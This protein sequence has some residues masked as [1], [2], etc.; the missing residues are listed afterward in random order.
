MSKKV[1]KGE[2]TITDV[3]DSIPNEV[4]F[5]YCAV[6]ST[7]TKSFVIT[8]VTPG[9][10]KFSVRSADNSP[11]KISH[12]SGVLQVK[13]KQEITF[14]YSPAECE[15]LVSSIVVN[16]NG[17]EDKQI[18]LLAVAK[19]QLLSVSETTLDFQELLVGKSEIKE[20]QIHNTGHVP[21]SFRVRKERN[22][23][24]DTSFFVAN[25]KGNIAVGES[26]TV[27]FKYQPKLVGV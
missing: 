26:A 10:M 11:F 17:E 21:A 3:I 9:I 6:E 4:D 18:K 16:I 25:K 22:E 5:G 12:E 14:S 7:E 1:K 2:K 8:N 15:V 24:E 13:G 20:I 23:E 27:K 19:Y